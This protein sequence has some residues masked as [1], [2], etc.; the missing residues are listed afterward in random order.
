MQENPKISRRSFL[1]SAGGTIVSIGLPGTFTILSDARQR[2][3]AADTRP[4]GR[5]RLPPGQVAVE[6]IRNMGG[7]PGTATIEDWRLRIHGEVEKPTVLCYRELL[8]LD[9][10]DITFRC[11]GMSKT[12]NKETVVS[13][14][15]L[16]RCLRQQ[17]IDCQVQGGLNQFDGHL[18]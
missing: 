5:P 15:D 8:N 2:A 17:T 9:Q 7:T 6:K 3:L 18:S 12:A 16:F 14:R 1:V 10:V 11:H 4:D 13:R